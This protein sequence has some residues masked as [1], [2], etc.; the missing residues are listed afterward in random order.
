MRKLL[1]SLF[2]AAV[3]AF[4]TVALGGTQSPAVAQL[5]SLGCTGGSREVCYMERTRDCRERVTNITFGPTGVGINRTCL[6]EITQERYYYYP[7]SPPPG[8]GA[9]GQPGG[10]SGGSSGGGGP[11]GGSRSPC[12]EKSFAAHCPTPRTL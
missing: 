4:G 12:M 7:P 9:P 8:A 6:S 2:A 11:S 3:L 5:P 1:L 10:G